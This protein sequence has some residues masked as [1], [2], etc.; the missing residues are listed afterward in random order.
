MALKELD[1]SEHDTL[2]DA[3]AAAQRALHLLPKVG[4][5]TPTNPNPTP[6]PNPNPCSS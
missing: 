3:L 4:P 2:A 1:S 5:A 6:N